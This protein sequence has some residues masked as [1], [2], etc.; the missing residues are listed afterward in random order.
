MTLVS[1]AERVEPYD[2]ARAAA[3]FATAGIVCVTFGE[4]EK[5]ALVRPA[6]GRTPAEPASDFA[7]ILGPDHPRGRPCQPRRPGE[8]DASRVASLVDRVLL[9]EPLSE[10]FIVCSTLAWMPSS[11]RRSGRSR[12]A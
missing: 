8:A 12:S 3:L 9:I 11:T 5:S 4:F 10:H 2:G 6:G 1:E 7:T